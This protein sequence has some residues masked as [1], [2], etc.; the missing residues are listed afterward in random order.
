[1]KFG[2]RGEAFRA[3]VLRFVR[4][5]GDDVAELEALLRQLAA[6]P[7]A[8]AARARAKKLAHD[9]KGAGGSYGFPAVSASAA[10]LYGA[11]AEVDLYRQAAQRLRELGQALARAR[12]EVAVPEPPGESLP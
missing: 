7:L 11:L 1:M 4:E 5:A 3:L 9:L 8:A 6:D 2:D 10:E 12:A